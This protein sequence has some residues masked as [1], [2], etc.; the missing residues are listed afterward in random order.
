[1]SSEDAGFVLS[2]AIMMLNTDLHSPHVRRHMSPNQWI[3]MNKGIV[4]AWCVCVCVFVCTH[5]WLCVCV[6]V[7]LC[8]YA[9]MHGCVSVCAC[10][11][12]YYLCALIFC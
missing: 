7:C 6:C 2:Y 12:M 3:K 1:M 11:P 10:T 4:I 8:L 9:L 5:A